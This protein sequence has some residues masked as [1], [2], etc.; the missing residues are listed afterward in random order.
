MLF[1]LQRPD[2][3]FLCTIARDGGGAAGLGHPGGGVR[4]GGQ[5]RLRGDVSSSS[6]PSG[7]GDPRG[8]CVPE[9]WRWE[10]RAPR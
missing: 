2:S 5:A 3:T 10:G 6:L 1:S 9:Q 4:A 8:V 7:L